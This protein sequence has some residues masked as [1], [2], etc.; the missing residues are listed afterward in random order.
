ML[1]KKRTKERAKPITWYRKA[2][3]PEVYT[4]LRGAARLRDMAGK[5]TLNTLRK[6]LL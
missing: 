4:P 2:G 6:I 5:L 3:L 1:T